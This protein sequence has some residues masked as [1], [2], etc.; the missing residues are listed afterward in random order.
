[1]LGASIEQAGCRQ[2]PPRDPDNELPFGSV[3]LPKNGQR[4]GRE[5]DVSGW[6]AD[7]SAVASIDIY[8]D[9][10]Y[11]RSSFVSIPRPDVAKAFPKYVK[12]GGS[13]GWQCSVDLGER[14]GAH[15]IL[16]QAVDTLGATRDLGSVTVQ[17]IGRE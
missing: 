7:D 3:D 4:V 10:R 2:K 8:V 12:P 11:E 6:A 14:P 16:A 13:P 5:V 9:G 15:A 17:L 1:L